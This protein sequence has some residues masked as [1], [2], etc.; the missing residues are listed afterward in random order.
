MRILRDY[1][2][3]GKL[4]IFSRKGRKEFAILFFSAL[5]L[6]GIQL[7]QTKIDM[8]KISILLFIM[9]FTFAFSSFSQDIL[10]KAD[11][12]KEQ[13]KITLLTDKEIQY[14]KFSNL[15]GPVFTIPKRDV[16]MITYEN[17]DF[18][19]MKNSTDNKKA[20]KT[21]LAE[22]FK[23]NLISFHLFDVVYYD[24]TVSYERIL[25]SG[26][27]G[28]QIPVGIGYAYNSDFYNNREEW[29]RNKFYS[30]IGINFYPTGQGKWRYFVGPN[31][32]VGYG[33]MIDYS[34]GYYDEYG[35]W[36]YGKTDVE[37]IYTKFYMDNGVIFTPVKNFSVEVVGGVGIRFFP[38]AGDNHSPVAPSGY[39]S[40]NMSYRF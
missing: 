13:V 5:S 27:I 12:T 15:D 11:G 7:N 23:K 16:M 32:R 10:Y 29:V 39:F 6:L 34:S 21:D 9:L 31:I 1:F 40:F 2:A 30:G 3:C 25:A 26:T 19:M 22:N 37:G 36:V 4:L 33:K 14:K 20:D 35:N 18:E 24:F 17:G 28:I 38:D 8:K